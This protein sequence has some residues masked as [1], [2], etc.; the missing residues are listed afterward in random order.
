MLSS[1]EIRQN[2]AA[3]DKFD[4]DEALDNAPLSV[5]T[6][7]II[8]AIAL[9]VVLEAVNNNLLGLAVPKL[10]DDWHLPREAFKYAVTFS[11]IGMAAGAF[12]SGFI[13]DKIG[14]RAV[15][16]LTLP[17][18]GVATIATGACNSMAALVA[19][20][21]F[22]GFSFGGLLPIASSTAAEFAPVRYRTM[23][24]TVP[25]VCIALGTILAGFLFNLALPLGGWRYAFYLGG[26]LPFILCAVLFFALPES[27]RFMAQNRQ[28]WPALRLLL[29]RLGHD[30]TALTVFADEADEAAAKNH[31][32]GIKALFQNGLAHDTIAIWVV[33]FFGIAGLYAVYMWLPAMLGAE[34]VSEAAA[35]TA[36][37]YWFSTGGFIGALLCAWACARFGSRRVM[38]IFA[39]GGAVTVFALLTFDIKQHLL[40]MSAFLGLHGLFNNGIQVPLYAIFAHLYPTYIRATGSSLA[41][42]IGKTGTIFAAYIG[43]IVSVT[44]YFFMLG[45]CMLIVAAALL[46]FR[47]H[48][49]PVSKK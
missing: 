28:T 40:L 46:V 29:R 36:M 8:F 14:R 2:P 3:A 49:P 27:P 25:I 5:T 45:F 1:L 21:F 22:V 9:A 6:A 7:G 37:S 17:I 30:T 19:L 32:G 20:R 4:I 11:M 15:I 38:I 10:V 43:G 35:R 47:R 18:C 48:I 13:A 24:V 26:I 16:L 31:K 23:A 39:I 42:S 12:I 34:G 41:S 33:S 44:E